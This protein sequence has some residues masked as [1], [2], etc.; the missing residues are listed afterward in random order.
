[1]A[2]ILPFEGKKTS[3]PDNILRKVPGR[4]KNIDVRSREYLTQDEVEALMKAA[5]NT[6]RHRHRD[7]MLILMLF[8]HGLR[9]SE[10]VDLRWDQVDFKAGS[11]HINRLQPRVPAPGNYRVIISEPESGKEKQVSGLD[12]ASPDFE[13]IVIRL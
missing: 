7:Q 2:K 12:T 3:P 9:V 11:I 5:G 1:M 13:E 8:R 4:T 6:G 10:A